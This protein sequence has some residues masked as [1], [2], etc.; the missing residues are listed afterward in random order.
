MVLAAVLVAP[1][2][3]HVIPLDPE[4]ISPQDG[5]NK[6]DC[7]QQA[8]KRWVKRNA[9]RFAPWK[10]TI[11]TDDLHSHEP[12]C[13]LLAN[14]KVHYIMTCRTESHQALY[15]E[16]NLLGKVEDAIQTMTSRRWNGRYHEEW[17][18]RWGSHV[19][20]RAGGNALR[21]NWCEITIARKDTG[22]LLYHNAWITSHELTGETVPEIVAAGRAHW[23]VENENF[24]VL[25]N[26]G[27]HFEHNYGHGKQHLSATLLTLLLLA[28]L[29]HTVLNICYS[30]YR[31]IRK[32]LVAR[33]TFF[34]DLRALT[35][36]LYFPNWDHL[37]SF[38][39]EQL[40]LGPI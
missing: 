8:I 38:M 29:L 26:R 2:K 35:R 12:L 28:F 5:H 23:K 24:N 10:L 22:R 33:E 32:K 31:A 18:Y 7:E 1:G 17:T 20:I 19:P 27:Y 6:Q 11:L 37:M 34:N 21:T 36:Y 30:P 39:H 3:E 40:E 13:E 14:N 16:V 25:K 15:R 4:F 9:G